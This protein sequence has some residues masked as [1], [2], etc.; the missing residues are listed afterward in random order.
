[1]SNASTIVDALLEADE[2]DPKRF[3]QRQTHRVFYNIV[4][5]QSTPEAQEFLGVIDDYGEQK[6]LEMLADTYDYH[7]MGGEHEPSPVPNYGSH[8]D[9]YTGDHDGHRYIL[10]YS[11]GLG[12]VGLDRIEDEFNLRD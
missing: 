12:T 10:S 11:R 6:A 5:L 1:M 8:D 9:V 4:F 7:D 2:I 3:V